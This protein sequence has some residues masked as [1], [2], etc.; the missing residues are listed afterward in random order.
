[1][2]SSGKQLLI[3]HDYYGGIW[4]VRM[5][6]E[7]FMTIEKPHW[8]SEKFKLQIHQQH[9]IMTAKANKRVFIFKENGKTE[10]L[11][12]EIKAKQMD[13]AKFMYQVSI[14]DALGEELVAVCFWLR[15]LMMSRR[16]QL[17]YS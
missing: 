8:F 1:M 17:A 11:Y 14:D 5:D 6:G 12:G 13:M 16:E 15:N 9:F 2:I 4:D 3:S 10:E 7:L